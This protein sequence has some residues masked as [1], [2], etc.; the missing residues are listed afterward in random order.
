MDRIIIVEAG[1]I[2]LVQRSRKKLSIL[3]RRRY[4]LMLCTLL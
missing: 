4:L 1:E 3:D 2:I